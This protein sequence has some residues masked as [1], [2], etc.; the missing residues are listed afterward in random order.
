MPPLFE[1]F[2]LKGAVFACEHEPERSVEFDALS[3]SPSGEAR[4]PA[5]NRG[6][7][8][9]RP[10]LRGKLDVLLGVGCAPPVLANRASS[11]HRVVEGRFTIGGGVG[12]QRHHPVG[13]AVERPRCRQRRLIALTAPKCENPGLRTPEAIRFE[14][15]DCVRD[16]ADGGPFDLIAGQPTDD[17][18]IAL[19]LER[20][21]KARLADD[22]ALNELNEEQRKAVIVQEDRTLVVAG[23]GTGKTH[24]MAAKARDTV[25]TGVAGATNIAFVTFTRK[26]AQEIRDR[27]ADL[28]GMEIGTLHHLARLIIARAE[29][30]KPTLTPLAEDESAQLECYEAWLL[31]SIQAD[32]SLL[33][34]LQ[35]RAQAFTRCRAPGAG[36][37]GQRTV[38]P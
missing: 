30:R 8:G 17:S 35:T 10:D 6:I 38:A 33:A 23:A 18:E 16:L 28:A 2:A 11:L 31:E 3:R 34:D 12:K 29:G 9:E 7:A 27:S 37:S 21:L 14:Y 24:T 15:P 19:A 13:V 4:L 5:G 22:P 1:F 26:A 32:P 20:L 36:A 25:R